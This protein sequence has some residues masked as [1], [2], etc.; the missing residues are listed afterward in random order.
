[1]EIKNIEKLKIISWNVNGIRAIEKKKALEPLIENENPDIICLQEIKIS[2]EN[3]FPSKY[4]NLGYE[5]YLSHCEVKKG[6]SGVA[7]LSKIKAEKI[8]K[9]I[10]IEKFDKEGRII[11]MEFE[12]TILFSIYFPNGQMS[13]ERL[14]YK[15]E[16]YSKFEEYVEN[17]KKENKFIIICGDV[18]T[19][20]KEIDLAR[21]KDNEN[22]SGFL[23]IERD[24]ISNFLNL[25]WL[26]TLREFDL[27]CGLYTWWSIRAIG[28][29]DRNVGWR[30]DYFYINKEFKTKLINAYILPKYLGSDHCPIGIDI[31]KK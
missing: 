22:T 25:G 7:I 24:W 2:S 18:N 28:A 26:D 29:R 23:K 27:S 4:K 15:M 11:Q 1:M 19:A 13:E 30:I 6:Y 12:N 9:G 14:N 3:D 20:H 8:K 17:L 16:F 10:G 21:P 31:L 5:V